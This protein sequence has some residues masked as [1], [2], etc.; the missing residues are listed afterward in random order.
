MEEFETLDGLLANVAKVSAEA[1]ENLVAFADGARRAR[2]LIELQTDIPLELDWDALKVSPPDVK[3]LKALCIECGFHRFVQEL[4]PDPKEPATPW[5]ADYITIDTPEKFAA[6]VADLAAQPTVLLRHR[7]DLRRPAARG[8]C[9]LV[10]LL[11]GRHRLFL[12]VRGP[13]GSR[14]LD[15]ATV[16]NALAPI[17]AEPEVEKIGQNV[18][19]DMLVLRRA[20]VSIGGPVTDTMVLSYLLE[21]GECNHNLD[22]LSQ[23]PARPRDDSDQRPDRQGQESIA[24]GSGRIPKVAEYAA[25][26]ADAT[27]RIETILSEH[28]RA[29]GL[30]ELYADL[31]R[32]LIH[33]LADMEA[34]GITV[35]VALLAKLSTEFAGRLVAIETEIYHLAGRV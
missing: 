3:T 14:C 5:M 1:E 17:L 26:D 35:D 13:A 33:V 22:Q 8:L 21:S 16:L 32:P 31:E 10:V 7:D 34:A 23:R 30:G 2:Q 28:I 11:E 29:E 9:R 25:E 18:K 20:G 19:Y 15:E 27:W 12:P 6:F 4:G 24:D